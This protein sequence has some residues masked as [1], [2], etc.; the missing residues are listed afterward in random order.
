MDSPFD[1]LVDDGLSKDKFA[2]R[3]KLQRRIFKLLCDVAKAVFVIKQITSIACRQTFINNGLFLIAICEDNEITLDLGYDSIYL[4]GFRL[5]LRF[6]NSVA[7]ILRLGV[8]KIAYTWKIIKSDSNFNFASLV[9][10][11]EHGRVTYLSALFCLRSSWASPH[12]QSNE[13]SSA[14]SCQG[15]PLL[16][17]ILAV[18]FRWVVE[19]FHLV[20]IVGDWTFSYICC[21]LFTAIASTAAFSSVSSW[22]VVKP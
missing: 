7:G 4:M 19:D 3:Q 15:L 2:F 21:V 14:D 16:P 5:N 17:K 18:L 20:F 12:T 6:R 10:W 9:L 22:L 1:L 8:R 13:E 11:G